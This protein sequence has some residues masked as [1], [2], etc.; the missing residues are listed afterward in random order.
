MATSISQISLWEVSFSAIQNVHS[1]GT[2]AGINLGT[3]QAVPNDLADDINALLSGQITAAQPMLP[4]EQLEEYRYGPERINTVD[5]WT[6]PDWTITSRAWSP[7]LYE[8][9]QRRCT[10]TWQ[11]L[12]NTALGGIGSGLGT[13]GDRPRRLGGSGIQSALTSTD[14]VSMTGIAHVPLPL[15]DSSRPSSQNTVQ[16]VIRPLR[17]TLYGK[18]GTVVLERDIETHKFILHGVNLLAGLR[19][20][21]TAP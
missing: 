7:L 5:G 2:H 10:T 1:G 19:A 20:Y 17:Y 13:A 3:V 12:R 8:L 18:G 15:V 14:V 9:H 21:L 11:A 16:I 4:E 6:D